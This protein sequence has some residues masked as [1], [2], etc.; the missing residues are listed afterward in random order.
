MSD[1]LTRLGFSPYDRVV[2]VHADDIGMCHAANVAL[3]RLWPHGLLTSC[4]AMVPCP[5]FAEAA[6]YA[7]STPGM[8][9]GVHITLTSEW[10]TYRWA[11]LSTRDPASGLLDDEGYMWPSVE[12]LV[13][14]AQ[15]QAVAA[16]MRA[17]LAAALRAGID[18]THIDAHMGAAL[19]P[20]F[21]EIYLEVAAEFGL[22]PFLPHLKPEEI[23]ALEADEQ[24]KELFRRILS[25]READRQPQI[26]HFLSTWSN[27]PEPNVLQGHR[28]LFGVLKPGITHLICHPAH[29]GAEL[30]AIMPGGWLDRVVDEHAFGLADFDAYLEHIS[31]KR[32]GYRAL[33]DLLAHG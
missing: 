9:M 28:A 2:I 32:I 1:T 30:E 16:E 13:A 25:R 5:W 6:E 15:P 3:E 21:I 23:D 12:Q 10:R 7:R 22:P 27:I 18:V 20:P 31:V 29:S 4:A 33:R 19:E 8:D 14:H 17:Q 24:R 11:P 26:D